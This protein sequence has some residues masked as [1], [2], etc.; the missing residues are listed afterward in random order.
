MN[1]INL[2]TNKNFGIT[3]FFVF[4]ILSTIFFFKKILLS[5][6]FLIIAFSFLVLGIKNSKILNP[7]NI[8]WFKFGLLLGKIVSPII[9]GIIY[10]IVI[11]PI[12]FLMKYIF[13][14]NLL[15]IKKNIKIK[16]YWK[17]R[18]DKIYKMKDQF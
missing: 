13:L 15:N 8:I 16:T 5:I 10:F 3:F 17:T 14:K 2:P 7:L 18:S 4:F 9:I 11:T 12:G 1:N 6:I